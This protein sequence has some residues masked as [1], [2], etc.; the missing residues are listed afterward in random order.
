[1]KLS[2]QA[3]EEFQQIYEKENQKAI[4]YNEAER[5]ALNLLRL[6]SA[7]YRPIKKDEYAIK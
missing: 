7:I 2:K 1:M 4:S 3:V 5:L 6:F